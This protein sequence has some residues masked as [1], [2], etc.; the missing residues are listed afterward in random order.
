METDA[1]ASLVQV[2]GPVFAIAALVV[3]LVFK[4]MG[5]QSTTIDNHLDHVE[6]AQNE[7]NK[8]LVEVAETNRA[9]AG[10]IDRLVLRID[11]LLTRYDR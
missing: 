6:K 5:R 2:G 8:T 10:S 4:H 11:G 1:I 3:V 7:G 9:V